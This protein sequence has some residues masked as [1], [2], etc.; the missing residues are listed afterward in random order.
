M[1]QL[2]G[3]VDVAFAFDAG[4]YIEVDKAKERI[5]DIDIRFFIERPHRKIL[6]YGIIADKISVGEKWETST[7]LYVTVY[8]DFCGISLRY[9]IPFKGDIESCVALSYALRDHTGLKHASQLHMESMLDRLK[10]AII[11]PEIAEEVEDYIFFCFESPENF[12]EEHQEKGSVLNNS[13]QILL[14]QYIK[15]HLSDI[16]RVINAEEKPLHKDIID[17]TLEHSTSWYM[18]DKIF[19]DWTSSFILHTDD[20]EGRDLLRRTVETLEFANMQLLQFAILN[21]MLDKSILQAYKIEER[22]KITNQEIKQL[23]EIH[24]DCME[25]FGRVSSG[26]KLYSN[27]HLAKLHQLISKRFE[28]EERTDE[29]RHKLSD[30][31]NIILG[32]VEKVRHRQSHHVEILIA[33]LIIIELVP[34]VFRYVFQYM[35]ESIVK[36]N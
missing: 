16:C 29:L 22:Q 11:K 24:L 1:F 32:I 12:K 18:Q 4:S 31:R 23:D 28:F 21:K 20:E 2:Q 14:D 5:T 3:Y 7:L 26:I 10:G 35:L 6:Q 19:V 34:P 25:L 9:R 15:H 13:H 30:L 8:P 27:K 36:D 17:E 33:V